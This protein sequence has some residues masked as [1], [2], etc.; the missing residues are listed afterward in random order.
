MVEI[1]RSLRDFKRHMPYDAFFQTTHVLGRGRI[2]T[3]ASILPCRNKFYFRD[4]GLPD[5]D[6]R[7]IFPPSPGKDGKNGSRLVYS[8]GG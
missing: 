8:H 1:S 2:T 6:R 5:F 7:H 3:R 4:Q